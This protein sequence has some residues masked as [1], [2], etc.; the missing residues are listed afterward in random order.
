MTA[1]KCHT[2]TQLWAVWYSCCA[3]R[4][5]CSVNSEREGLKSEDGDGEPPYPC[6]YPPDYVRSNLKPCGTSSSSRS[7]TSTGTPSAVGAVEAVEAAPARLGLLPLR[8]QTGEG[9]NRDGR[10]VHRCAAGCRSAALGELAP[11]VAGDRAVS[12]TACDAVI[13]P[14]LINIRWSPIRD[15]S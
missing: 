13:C 6:P 12:R 9:A 14:A 5:S 15:A 3:T 2:G 7:P 8:V 4:Y 10:F 11:I 1:V